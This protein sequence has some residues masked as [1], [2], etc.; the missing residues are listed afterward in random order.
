ME[1]NGLTIRL[2]NG[3]AFCTNLSLK[4]SPSPLYSESTL[5]ALLFQDFSLHY[6]KYFM[7]VGMMKKNGR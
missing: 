1:G 2:L 5:K 7:E 6:F 3:R 4:N